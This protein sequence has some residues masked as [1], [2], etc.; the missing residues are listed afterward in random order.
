MDFYMCNLILQSTGCTFS[1]DNLDFRVQSFAI[2]WIFQQVYESIDTDNIVCLG[3]SFVQIAF[4][5]F[6]ERQWDVI[7]LIHTECAAVFRQCLGVGGYS[8]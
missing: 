4:R 2:G 8:Y 3:E 6:L 7:Y 5:V 1:C